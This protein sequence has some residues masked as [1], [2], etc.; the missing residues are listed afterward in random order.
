MPD[1][2]LDA[3]ER[4]GEGEDPRAFGEPFGPLY[5]A[6]LDR[7]HAAEPL[8]LAAGKLVLGVRRQP[9]IV[10]ALDLGVLG[11]PLGDATAV[12]VVLPHAQCERLGSP[13]RE[14]TVERSR[15]R[16]HRVL[17]DANGRRIAEWLA[18]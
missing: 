5:G 10:D 13:E 15:Y 3:T 2:A 6:Q 14:P 18:Q 1:Q 9:R 12:G 7:D 8:H 4:F 11:E 16:A 17:H